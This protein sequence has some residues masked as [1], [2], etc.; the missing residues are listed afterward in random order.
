VHTGHDAIGEV[1]LRVDFDGVLY[2]GRAA[3]TDVIAGS[4]NAYL[5]ALNRAVA[6]KRRR[7]EASSK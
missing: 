1:F 4:V 7:E 6:S 2:N 5:E 3:S